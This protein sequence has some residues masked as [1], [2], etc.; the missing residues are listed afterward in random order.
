MAT[1]SQNKNIDQP[2]D[3]SGKVQYTSRRQETD[4]LR[5]QLR[6]YTFL[7]VFLAVLL[8]A[9]G[10]Y[11]YYT[12]RM[13]SPVTILLDGRSVATARSLT[14]AQ[15]ILTAAEKDI[16]GD[17]YPSSSII[18][19]QKI[20]YERV[21]VNTPIDSEENTRRMLA[22][23]LHLKVRAYVIM[24]SRKP[25]IGLPTAQQAAQTLNLVKQHYRQLP[26][27]YPLYQDPD[28]IGSVVIEKQPVAASQTKPTPADAAAYLYEAPPVKTYVVQEHDLGYF[29]AKKFHISFTDFLN[30]NPGRDLNKLKPGDT[31]NISKGP[32]HIQVRV[33]KKIEQN[34]KILQ[35]ADTDDAG[36]RHVTYAV[37]YINGVEKSR[38][39]LKIVTLTKPK[40]RMSL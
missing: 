8:I 1:P 34:E 21:P 30:A 15:K 36:V 13:G 31:V 7:I 38:E 27:N 12:R 39:V 28:I 32:P 4:P 37:N 14:T 2:G 33:V 22:N 10:G 6:L 20:Q 3:R 26:P 9:F 17:A 16:V 25:T 18:R 11:V 24:V 23:K 5:K 35:D 29:I 40:P 19:L